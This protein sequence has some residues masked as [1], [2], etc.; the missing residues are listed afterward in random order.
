MALSDYSGQKRKRNFRQLLVPRAL[1]S[2]PEG[3]TASLHASAVI[4]PTLAA[5]RATNR[6]LDWKGA[7]DK[8]THLSKRLR[9]WDSCV[10][11][12]HFLMKLRVSHSL[13]VPGLRL[14]CKW[15]IRNLTRFLQLSDG[16]PSERSWV[17]WEAK[18]KVSRSSWR[19][20]ET[21][22]NGRNSLSLALAVSSGG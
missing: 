12:L 9:T 8:L 3:V 2:A 13:W 22:G 16:S 6:R 21:D 7:V 17:K 19:W 14:K 10:Q 20:V 1:L 11:L 5:A 18:R 15:I 4:Q